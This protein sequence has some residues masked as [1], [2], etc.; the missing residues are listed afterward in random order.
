MFA[1]YSKFLI[2]IHECVFSCIEFKK[3][4]LRRTMI[5]DQRYV[6]LSLELH[7]YFSRIMKEHSF[8][9]KAGFTPKDSQ[10]ADIAE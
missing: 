1:I 9:L 6:I 7:L 8:F 4:N 3:M 5:N 10:L 2:Q